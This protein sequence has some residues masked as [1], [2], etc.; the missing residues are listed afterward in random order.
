MGKKRGKRGLSDLEKFCLCGYFHTKDA[1]MAYRLARGEEVKATDFNLHRMALR[2]LRSSLA[3]EYL[4]ALQGAALATSEDTDN[5]SKDDV[6]SELNRLANQVKEPKERATIL[7]KLAD[8]QN[9]KDEPTEQEK[10]LEQKIRYHLP[11]RYPTSCDDCL[12]RLNGVNSIVVN[13]ERVAGKVR[14]ERSWGKRPQ[15]T[16]KDT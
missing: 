7:M 10:E 4:K 2:W 3:Q 6:I 9:M 16:Q 1:D 11:V 14:L 15:G 13:G 8:L 5:R 12:I